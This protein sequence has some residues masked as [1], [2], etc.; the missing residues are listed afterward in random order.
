MTPAST[1]LTKRATGISGLDAATHG[2]LPAAGTVLVVGGPGSGKTVLGLQVIAEAVGRGEGGVYIS[3]EESREQ[4]LRDTAAFSWG[5]RLHD[6]QRCELIDARRRHGTEVAGNFD[7]DGLLAALEHCRQHVAG[8]WVV[9]DGLD[10]LLRLQTS[11]ITALDQITRLADWCETQDQTLLLT[12]KPA[13]G[14]TDTMQPD[15]LGGLEYLLSTVL[16]LSSRLVEQSLNRRLRIAKYRGTAHITNELGLLINADGI[17]L[18]YARQLAISEAA[19]PTERISTGIPRLDH[20]LDGG[21]YRGSTTLVSGQ[22]GTS[23]T[24]LAAAFAEAA[25]E[26]GERVLFFS[27]D[28]FTPQIVRNV[29]SIG[30]DLQLHIDAGNLRVHA[31][32]AWTA[33]VEEHYLELSEQIE[34]FDPHCVVIDPASALLKAASSG[35]AYL[36]IERL[37]LHTRAHGITTL[38]TSLSES[39]DPVGESS[40]S[41]TSTL[42]DTWITLRYQVVGGER[43]RALS[44]VKARGTKHSNQV[45]EMIVSANGVDLADVYSFGSEVLMGTARVQRESEIRAEERHQAMVREQRQR[46]LEREL[47]RARSRMEDAQDEMEQ[48]SRQLDQE[49]REREQRDRE[50][51]QHHEDIKARRGAGHGDPDPSRDGPP[52]DGPPRDGT[53]DDEGGAR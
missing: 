43:N 27:F 23:K 33:L 50:S 1:T 44:V 39:D 18:P 13:A 6:T 41:H 25:A 49:S 40:L 45:R 31:R 7:I 17:H 11:S 22:P 10:Q 47:A 37:L 5:E 14:D 19:A 3:F 52:R 42:A 46:D 28:E 35:H 48:L 21:L 2:G 36:A 30:I 34:R 20:V 12:A 24:T 32:A 29:G 9:V 53:V 4:I 15:Y 8:S 51:R 16:V 26:R 38:L